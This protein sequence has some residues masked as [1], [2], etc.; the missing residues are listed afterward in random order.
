MMK[1]RTP[2]VAAHPAALAENERQ[3]PSIMTSIFRGLARHCPSCGEKPA[4][5]SYLKQVEVCPGCGAA[6]GEIRA[7]DIPPYFTILLVGHIVVPLILIVEQHFE[8]AEWIEMT[9]WPSLTLMLTLALLPY[10][11]GGVLGLMWAHRMRGD[12]QH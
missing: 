6:L 2:A 1:F 10:I 7:D 8:P 11:K 5:R 12:E 9:V 3:R 4:F